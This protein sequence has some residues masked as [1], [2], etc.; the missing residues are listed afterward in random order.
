MLG[1]PQPSLLLHAAEAILI[2]LT[3]QN[4]SS[5]NF[6]CMDFSDVCIQHRA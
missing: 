5:A 3:T 6:R 1:V 4:D 2:H